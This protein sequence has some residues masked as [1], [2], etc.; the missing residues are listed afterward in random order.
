MEPGEPDP[1]GPS[2]LCEACEVEA[3][4]PKVYWDLI[5]ELERDEAQRADK[6]M[7]DRVW[8]DWAVGGDAD[9][10]GSSTC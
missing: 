9:L 1:S 2:E 10:P 5:E 6:V 3:E 4:E 7:A 8:R